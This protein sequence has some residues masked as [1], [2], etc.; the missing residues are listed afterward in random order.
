[1]GQHSTARS[2]DRVMAAAGS[3]L[4]INRHSQESSKDRVGMALNKGGEC[5]APAMAAAQEQEPVARLRRAGVMGEG[6]GYWDVVVLGCR[7]VGVLRCWGTEV[8]GCRGSAGWWQSGSCAHE[9]GRGCAGSEIA[10]PRRAEP[11]YAV[12]GRDSPAAIR[13]PSGGGAAQG[14]SRDEQRRS[15]HRS[16]PPGAARPGTA[17]YGTVRNAHRGSGA[18]PGA[19]GLRVRPA[20][21][22]RRVPAGSGAV[23]VRGPALPP[24]ACPSRCR[25]GR[26]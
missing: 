4:D 14:G 2:K 10:G 3:F 13:V 24:P 21:G 26:G 15:G 20:R 23:P 25:G 16:A 11:R 7:G 22:G 17:R 9:Q 8:S 5:P 1:M 12:P 18:A 19:A 6:A